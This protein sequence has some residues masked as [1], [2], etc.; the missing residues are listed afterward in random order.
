MAGLWFEALAWGRE[1]DAAWSHPIA[2]TDHAMVCSTTV[3]AHHV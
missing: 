3:T 1:I 2:D